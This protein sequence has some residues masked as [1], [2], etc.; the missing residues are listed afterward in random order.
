MENISPY[1]TAVVATAFLGLDPTQ[2][3]KKNLAKKGCD[4]IA[5]QAKFQ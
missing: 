4:E 5:Q 1:G 3:R 2:H